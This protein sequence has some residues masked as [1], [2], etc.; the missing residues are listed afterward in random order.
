MIFLELY[1]LGR[2]EQNQKSENINMLK[3]ANANKLQSILKYCLGTYTVNILKRIVCWE[4][5]N[6]D[7]FVLSTESQIKK[8]CYCLLEF[9]LCDPFLTPPSLD[10]VTKLMCTKL[11]H[12]IKCAV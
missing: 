7:C 5:L 1:K 4:V 10:N 9:L 6:N 3:Q 8:I 11:C 12:Q 2:A